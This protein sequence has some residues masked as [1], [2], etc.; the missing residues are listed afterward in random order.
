MA[1]TD[2]H[3]VTD[4]RLIRSRRGGYP[5]FPLPMMAREARYPGAIRALTWGFGILDS[6]IGAIWTGR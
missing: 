5:P 1:R 2:Q 4:S 3:V 6:L